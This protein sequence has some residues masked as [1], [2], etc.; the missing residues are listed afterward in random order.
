[1]A[2][3]PAPVWRITL[4]RRLVVTAVLLG[5]WAI[6]VE[7]RLIYL[8]VVQHDAL[9]KKAARQQSYTQKVPGRRGELLDRNG[10]VLALSAD[11]QTV[12]A[13][14]AAGRGPGFIPEPRRDHRKPWITPAM[15][16]IP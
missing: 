9:V 11:S 2:E 12:T 7:A 4:K 8:Q 10:Q 13:V 5:L 14:P 15:G 1:M 3:L 6:G 16:F